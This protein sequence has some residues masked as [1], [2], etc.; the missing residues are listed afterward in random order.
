MSEE[1]REPWLEALMKKALDEGDVS[2]LEGHGKPL[3]AL[4]GAY[5]PDWW[6]KDKLRREKLTSLPRELE[7]KRKVDAEKVALLGVATEGEVRR[8]LAA[9]NAEI[10]HFN[11]HH[12]F[13]PTSNLYLVDLETFVETWLQARRS[14]R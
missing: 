11:A 4:D 6:L 1:S 5:D 10:A 13:G 12:V 7:L 14:S 8:R 2:R 9:I 3:A